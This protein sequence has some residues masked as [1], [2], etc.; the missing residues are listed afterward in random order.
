V[1]ELSEAR[2][3]MIAVRQRLF[4]EYGPFWDRPGALP[5]ELRLE[6]HPLAWNIVMTS[7]DMDWQAIDPGTPLHDYAEQ[8]YG[9]PVKINPELPKAA[10]RLVIVTEKVLEGG[11]LEW[12]AARSAG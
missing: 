8:A 9:V 3:L 1:P 2:A 10:W 4:D 6:L 7:A 12:Q 5:P 11:T